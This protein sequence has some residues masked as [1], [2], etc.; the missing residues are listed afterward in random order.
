MICY[1]CYECA[2]KHGGTCE[3]NRAVTMHTGKCEICEE[4]KGLCSPGDYEWK[5]GMPESFSTFSDDDI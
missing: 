4:L 5:N 3:D 2:I 1:I